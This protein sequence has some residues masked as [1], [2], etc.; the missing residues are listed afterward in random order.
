MIKPN[1]L[2]NSMFTWL[3]ATS[4][5]SGYTPYWTYPPVASGIAIS[6]R[7]RQLSNSEM[8]QYGRELNYNVY[9]LYVDRP[10]SGNYNEADRFYLSGVDREH[11]YEVVGTNEND[12]MNVFTSIDL[13]EIL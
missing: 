6:G 5:V 8:L 2:Y 11:T 13:K 10:A 3:Q 4:G 9:R 7:I 12:N 1:H